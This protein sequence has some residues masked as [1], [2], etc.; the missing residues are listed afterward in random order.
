[1]K[2][3][4]AAIGAVLLAVAL[5]VGLYS[6]ELP[7]TRNAT[8]LLVS[9]HPASVIIGKKSVSPQPEV[10]TPLPASF[11]GTEIYGHLR[12]DVSG[13][14]IIEQEIRHLFDYFLTSYGEEPLKNSIERLRGYIVQTL[15]EPARGEA[16]TLLQH[17][18]DYKRELI[19]LER[20][21]P[22][23][24]DLDS[25]ARREQSASSLRARVFSQEAHLAFFGGEEAYNR[26]TL[27]RM[28]IQLNPQLTDEQKGTALQAQRDNLPES[29]QLVAVTELQFELRQ[30]TA[31]LNARGGNAAELRSLRQQLVGSEAAERLEALDVRRT[32]WQARLAAFREERV[33]IE[34]TKGLSEGDRQ[35]AIDA[36]IESRFKPEEQLRLEGALVQQNTRESK[37]RSD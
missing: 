26:F 13:H 20:S 5:S 37:V 7:A 25:F 36:L 8:T 2:T 10:L 32:E 23:R 34:A 29:L 14:L 31:E 22:Q 15:Q 21:Q 19:E 17:Y 4:L 28:A 18:L 33:R 24:S 30:K 35:V 27:E 11:R 16:L 6:S 1:M 12:V 3:Y 9:S